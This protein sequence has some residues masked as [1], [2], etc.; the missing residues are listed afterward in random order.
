MA[1]LYLK[2]LLVRAKEQIL[3]DLLLTILLRELISFLCSHM[4]TYLMNKYLLPSVHN[5][6]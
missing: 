2:I 4:S 1:S 5:N 3:E 6:F